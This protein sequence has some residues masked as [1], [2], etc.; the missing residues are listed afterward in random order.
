MTCIIKQWHYKHIF[1]TTQADATVEELM[2][3]KHATIGE[4]LEAMFSMRSASRIYTGNRNGIAS[5]YKRQT[6]P[7]VRRDALHQ[8]TRNCLTEIK[9]W[10]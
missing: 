2:E 10:S 4:L 6:R 1:A 3:K 7:L 8:Q 9:I 5:N